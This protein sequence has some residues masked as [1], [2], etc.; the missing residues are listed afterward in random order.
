M[1]SHLLSNAIEVHL[2]ELDVGSSE[3]LQAS[4]GLQ[5]VRLELFSEIDHVGTEGVKGV[6][7][8]LRDSI[9]NFFRFFQDLVEN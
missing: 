5:E 9:K 8:V 7:L 2:L 6:F 1:G 4:V 3:A